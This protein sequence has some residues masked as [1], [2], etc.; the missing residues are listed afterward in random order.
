MSKKLFCLCWA[1]VLAGFVSALP[2]HA[3]PTT[4][5]NYRFLVDKNLSYVTINADGSADVEYWL[6]FTNLSL[7]QPVDIVDVGLPHEHYR[8]DTAQADID[9]TTL[10]A[11]MIWNC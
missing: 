8:L 5:Q 4:F 1:L 2:L 7:G 10:K 6:T 11:M 9:G 3:R